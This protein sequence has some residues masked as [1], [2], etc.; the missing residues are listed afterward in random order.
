MT[1]NAS[2]L[3]PSAQ[4]LKD[5]GMAALNISLDTLRADRFFEIARRDDL[6]NVLAGIDAALSADFETIKLNMVVMGGVNDDEVL[7]FVEMSKDTHIN[8]RF[9]EYM[10][11]KNNG[12]ESTKVVTMK[13]LKELIQTKHVLHA[14]ET[15]TS[16]VAKDFKIEGH[17]GS[18]SF[19]SSMSDS[20]CAT[21]NRLR[22][23]STGDVKSCLFYP[24]EIGLK[25]AMRR[26]ATDTELEVMILHSL[27]M[28][29]EAHPPAE[30]IATMENRAMIEIGG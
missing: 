2:L 21:C 28:K 11:F 9:I 8:V 18:V 6:K 13:E 26:G 29:P 16:A 12:W 4:R 27:N 1:T 5:A 23:T 15:D 17:S 30:E 24:A 3:A 25:E 19:I 22:L 10:P 7:D 14:I 20:F